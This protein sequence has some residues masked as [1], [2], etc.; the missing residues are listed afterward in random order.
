MM[1]H[2]A[3]WKEMISVCLVQ[4]IEPN[5]MA[6]TL[7]LLKLVFGTATDWLLVH[8]QVAKIIVRHLPN[9]DLTASCYGEDRV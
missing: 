6:S 3:K 7:V 9:V 4:L 1:W 8:L 5:K 2:M